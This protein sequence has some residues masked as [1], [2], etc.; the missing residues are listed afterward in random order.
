[1]QPA[2][3][4]E[5]TESLG[6]SIQGRQALQRPFAVAGVSLCPAFLSPCQSRA[7]DVTHQFQSG[8]GAETHIAPEIHC[9]AIRERFPESTSRQARSTIYCDRAMYRGRD[10]FVVQR[11]ENGVLIC[12]ECRAA[13]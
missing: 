8:V 10:R 3:P 11:T 13:I 12:Y 7:I 9:C 5:H 6:C 1:M 2:E 4:S